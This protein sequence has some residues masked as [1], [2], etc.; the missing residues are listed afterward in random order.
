VPSSEQ[1]DLPAVIALAVRSHQL[2]GEQ[3]GRDFYSV[4]AL[5]MLLDL[6]LLKTRRPRSLSS[7]CG[8]SQAPIRTAL[9][10]INRLVAEGLLSRTPDPADARR[11]NVA[12]TPKGVALL[13]AVFEA[14]R[15][16]FQAVLA[17]RQTGLP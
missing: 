7:L 17:S 6:Y 2:L 15:L 1:I 9:R 5:D 13:D 8:A 14:L 10:A 4:P 11:V 3:L 12:L 16:H